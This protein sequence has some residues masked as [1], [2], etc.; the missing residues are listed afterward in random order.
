MLKKYSCFRKIYQ[1]LFYAK[2][3]T[4][5]ATFSTQW[6]FF[7]VMTKITLPWIQ[8]H[9]NKT[10]SCPEYSGLTGQRF[11]YPQTNCLVFL[12]VFYFHDNMFKSITN[13]NQD[14]VFYFFIYFIIRHL[15]IEFHCFIS[16]L[17]WFFGYLQFAYIIRHHD[18]SGGLLHAFQ[19]M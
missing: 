4:I 10:L 11:W 16:P 9:R 5:K 12:P 7:S 8:Q 19:S 18:L 17:R 6:E 3:S 2:L 15:Q 14:N 1:R 13:I